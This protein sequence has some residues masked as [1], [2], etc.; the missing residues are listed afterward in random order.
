[1][2][3][4]AERWARDEWGSTRIEMNV[5]W[6]RVELIAWYA[7]RGYVRTGEKR[8]FPYGQLVNGAALRDD[9]YFDVLAKAL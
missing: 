6:T 8:P 5:I 2:L 1:V 3:G 7:R 4:R 9:L